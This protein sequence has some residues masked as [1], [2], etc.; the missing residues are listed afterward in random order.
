MNGK[1]IAL[2]GLG[3]YTLAIQYYDKTLAIDPKFTTAL[4]GK[5]IALGGLGNYTLAIPYF[6]KALNID[7]KSTATLNGK[8]CWRLI[9]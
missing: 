7:P 4:N 8:V 9:V 3:N 1:G 6:D 2:G 5:G